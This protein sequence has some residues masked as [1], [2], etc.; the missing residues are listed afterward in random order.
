MFIFIEQG[1]AMKQKLNTLIL[2]IIALVAI[3]VTFIH[4][5]IADISIFHGFIL[6]PIFLLASLSVLA[7]VIEQTSHE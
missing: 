7:L 4:G 2:T 6:H 3:L 5:S 1:L